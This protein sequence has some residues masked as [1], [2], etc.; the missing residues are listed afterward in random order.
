MKAILY[1]DQNLVKRTI[2][3]ISSPCTLVK[4]VKITDN[5]LDT[6][7]SYASALYT[8]LTQHYICTIIL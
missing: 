1:Q 8:I 5:P 3:F 4:M 6:Y 2:E 7:L